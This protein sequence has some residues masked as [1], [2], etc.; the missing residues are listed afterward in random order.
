MMW[1]WSAQYFGFCCLLSGWICLLRRLGLHCVEVQLVQPTACFGPCVTDRGAGVSVTYGS[2]SSSLL[3]CFSPCMFI[4]HSPEG[5][6]H[7]E[8]CSMVDLWHPGE[9]SCRQQLVFVALRWHSHFMLF[10]TL[11]IQLH[12]HRSYKGISGIGYTV[13]KWKLNE[14]S[15]LRITGLQCDLRI[16]P[17]IMV[18]SK[19]I[20]LNAWWELV[21]F[22]FARKQVCPFFTVP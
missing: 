6:C 20:S 10:F 22:V 14:N 9:I 4:F 8:S 18:F 5:K 16:M 19:N 3:L 21:Y 17:V 15:V 11:L 7:L 13:L 12:R 2:S 1:W